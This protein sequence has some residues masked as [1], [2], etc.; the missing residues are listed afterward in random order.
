M[1]IVVGSPMAGGIVLSKYPGR[2][3][4]DTC[5]S[6]NMPKSR[7]IYSN[8]RAFMIGVLKKV[9]INVVDVLENDLLI[10]IRVRTPCRGS[11]NGGEIEYGIGPLL[12]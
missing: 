1:Q 12:Q 5:I 7:N 8:G 9:R 10:H 2:N 6:G 4:Y 11:R 3:K